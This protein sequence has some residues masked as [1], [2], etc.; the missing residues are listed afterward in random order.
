MKMARRSQSDFKM[1]IDVSLGVPWS[2]WRFFLERSGLSADSEQLAYA[3]GYMPGSH[4]I[5]PMTD[6]EMVEACPF[7]VK[8]TAAVLW[9]D[10]MLGRNQICVEIQDAYDALRPGPD[11]IDPPDICEYWSSSVEIL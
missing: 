11:I 3:V 1:R 4:D 10:K 9:K 8:T 5:P 7:D 2:S 6:W